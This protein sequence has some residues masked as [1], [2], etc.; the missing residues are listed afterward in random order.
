MVMWVRNGRDANLR[1]GVIASRRSFRRAVDRARAK[2][3]LREAYRLNR[4]KLRGKVDVILLARPA[5]LGVKRQAVD[6]DLMVL[7]RKAGLK[8]R[9]RPNEKGND[10]D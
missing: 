10:G 4:A 6:K 5:I 3:L 1:L 9:D 8:R 2:R 7:A